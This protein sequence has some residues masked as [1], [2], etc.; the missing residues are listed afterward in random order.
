MMKPCTTTI[1]GTFCSLPLPIIGVPFRS[2]TRYLNFK[3]VV[4]AGDGRHDFMGHSA[5]YGTFTIFCCTV[6]L[7]IHIVVVQV[8]LFTELLGEL[9]S[10]PC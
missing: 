10:A 1:R 5:K 3:E 2:V 6:G 9:T 4:L 8:K 7:I